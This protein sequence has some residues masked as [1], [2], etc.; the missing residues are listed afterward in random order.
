MK[1]IFKINLIFFLFS[2]CLVA[3]EELIFSHDHG[4]Y[5]NPFTLTVSVANTNASIRYTLDGTN[6]MTSASAMVQSTPA[7]VGID[8]ALTAGRDLAP[9]FIITVCAT[10]NDTLISDIVSQ[11]YLFVN[12]VLQLSPDNQKPGAA[13]MDHGLNN[14]QISYGMD[15]EIYNN[16]AYNPYMQQALLQAPSMSLITDLANLFDAEDGIY[17]N[18]NMHG[19]EWE[20]PA[21]LELL[22][23][24][25][26]EG[27]QINCGIRIR[28]GWSRHPE[29]PKH[30]FRV[31]FRSEYGKGKLDYPLFGDEGADEYDKVDLRTSQNYSWSYYGDNRNSFM[32]DV[33]SRDT[34]G[35]M[36]QPYTRSRFYHLYINGTYWGLFQTQERSEAAYAEAYFGGNKDDYDTIKRQST[37]NYDA[38][39]VEATDGNLDA[40]TKLWDMGEV[41][42][43]DNARYFEAQGLNPDGTV[44]PEFEKLLD[45]DNLIDYMLNTFYVGDFDGPVSAFAGNQ[46]SNNFYCIYNRVNPDGFKF[47]R[48][49]AEH[50][51]FNDGDGDNCCSDRTGPFPAGQNFSDSNPQWTHQQLSVNALYRARFADRA[52]KHM[53]N[54]GALTYQKSI[55]RINRRKAEIDLAII[56]E[57][58]RWGD[59]KNDT[60]RNK[61]HWENAVDYIINDFLPGRTE[62][63]LNQLTGKGLFSA[64][65]PPQFVQQGGV[66]SKGYSINFQEATNPIFYTLDGS[67]PFTPFNNDENF[68]AEVIIPATAKK[69]I[70]PTAD[71]GTTWRTDIN[72]ND[73]SWLDCSG[74]PGGIG[75]ETD[76]GLENLI[77]L[78]VGSYML[79]GNSN[80]NSSCYIR[81]PFEVSE[82]QLSNAGTL[83]LH[84]LYD[85]GFVA[86]LNGVQVASEFA[87]DPPQWNSFST[88]LHEAES[89]QSFNISGA[90][91]NLHAGTNLLAIQGINT[92]LTSSDFMILPILELSNNAIGGS[93]SE[94]AIEYTE[95][96]TINASVT[97]K[98]RMQQGNNW[99]PLNE[100][101]FLVP[102][103]LNDLRVTELHYHPLPNDT[104][105]SHTEYE[106]IEFKNVGSS[107]LNLNAVTFINGITYT[108]PGGS[109]VQPGGFIVLASNALEFF[110]R[111]GFQAFG[112]YEGQ[113]ANGG[114]RMVV[115]DA[116]GDTL[117]DFTYSDD[118]PWPSQADGAGYSL[119]ALNTNGLGHPGNSTYWAASGNIHGSPGEDDIVSDV[120]DGDRPNIP[121]QFT[122][123]Q[124]F[125]NPFNPQTVIR[126]SLPLTSK[127][128]LSVYEI[129]GREIKTLVDEYKTA[130][131]Y[132]VI[133]NAENLATGI[134]IYKIEA[135]DFTAFRKM[136]LIK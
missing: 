62:A 45:V 113:L 56:A 99:S 127:V 1:K 72:F 47:F 20:R 94:S 53:F 83:I 86:Y 71:I 42:F 25:G 21:S 104:L 34:Q 4:I 80:P 118:P 132:K 90:L 51:L 129:T 81:I 136:V 121:S 6:P 29:N 75:Y 115:I 39:N 61:T 28:G 24:D 7:S 8:P 107:E 66:V 32:R 79:E 77:S 13:W 15:P 102:L 134:Y 46:G 43:E 87:P 106:F 122:L 92:S 11:T 110:T 63:V 52:Y 60:P 67:D 12:R 98:A 49:D 37:E 95:P 111:Y 74:T 55:E 88:G 112:E 2:G 73:D 30:A 57:S 96:V 70:V 68:S 59:S 36:G 124:N 125:P 41:G 126:Y 128:K 44:N 26:S 40:W 18:A 97:I 117:F 38:R 101:S 22:N 93:P 84:M 131:E 33:F 123:Q 108:F 120:E 3:Q 58:A 64:I 114:E 78:N 82:E 27:F 16:A 23:P 17:V 109:T 119:V 69:V 5:E 48:H 54:G 103:D 19:I 133:F 85:D 116:V 9:G 10:A 135:G 89:Y 65:Q 14:Q 76:S 91:Q 31:F 105:V 130:G 35:E 100:A 50:S